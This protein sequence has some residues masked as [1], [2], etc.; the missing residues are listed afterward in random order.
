MIGLFSPDAIDRYLPLED[1]A[2]F[3]SRKEPMRPKVLLAKL[4]NG[5]TVQ[6]SWSQRSS[7]LRRP[8][9]LIPAQAGLSILHFGVEGDEAWMQKE[10]VIGWAICLDGEVRAVGPNGIRD[11]DERATY[12]EFPDGAVH[13]VGDFADPVRFDNA[14]A[15]RDHFAAEERK[16]RADA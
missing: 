6:V 16:D 7:L 8:V 9:Q 11:D 5:Q 3:T 2:G 4:Q 13:A 15:T 1:L 10:P 14:E 12:V